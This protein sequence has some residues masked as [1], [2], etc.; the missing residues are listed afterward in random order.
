MY[1]YESVSSTSR[2][3]QYLAAKGGYIAPSDFIASR[4]A[5]LSGKPGAAPIRQRYLRVD[6]F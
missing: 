2:L 5:E 4:M 1:G 6:I 3:R